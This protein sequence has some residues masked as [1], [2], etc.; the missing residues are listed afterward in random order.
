VIRLEGSMVRVQEKKT[1]KNKKGQKSTT[2]KG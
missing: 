2:Q 1:P